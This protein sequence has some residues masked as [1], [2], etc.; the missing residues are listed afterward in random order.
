MFDGMR[1]EEIAIA[2]DGLI[3]CFGVK[4]DISP[5]ALYDLLEKNDTEG[6]VQEI[7][8]LLELPIRISL[9]YVPK[10]YRPDNANSF[11]SSSLSK[12]DWTG[13]GTE[14]IIA[15]VSIPPHMPMYGTSSFQGYSISVR[16][17]EN[18]SSHPET[19]VAIMAHELSHV[20]LAALMSPYKDSELHTDLVPIIL[21]FRDAVRMGRKRIE[22]TTSGNTTTTHTT[23]YGYLTDSQFEYALTSDNH[24]YL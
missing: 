24:S 4:E 18:C 14:G 20:L 12:T 17:S 16:V 19:F 8:R 5:D 13:R 22:S 10:D 11:R 3:S 9:S 6:C 2:L 15:Q 21:G 1:N 7:A 23:T